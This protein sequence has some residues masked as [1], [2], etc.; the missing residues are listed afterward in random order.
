MEV[1]QQHDPA[2]TPQRGAPLVAPYDDPLHFLEAL[3]DGSL[4]EGTS[5]PG[6]KNN[7]IVAE[8]LDAAR[9]SAQTGTTIT[10]PL[11]R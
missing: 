8:I 9:R 3:L 11:P 5:T 6:L 4:D 7:V 1:R 10:L 2:A